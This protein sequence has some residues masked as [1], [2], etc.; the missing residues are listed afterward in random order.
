[1]RLGRFMKDLRE[2]EVNDTVR[3]H[4]LLGDCYILD[5]DSHYDFRSKISH[6]YGIHPEE[7]HVVG[8]GQL[9]F[10]IADGKR[11]R[12]FSVKSDIDVAIV[13]PVLFDRIWTAVVRYDGQGS[14]WRETKKMFR[15]YLMNGWI[16]PDALP[17]AESFSLTREWWQFFQELSSQT[18]DGKF[19]VSAGLY[20]TKEFLELYQERS[21]RSC[22]AAL[23][24]TR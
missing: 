20:R 8:S 16:R 2:R 22:K 7:V 17:Q 23:E 6:H 1:M 14:D 18:Q 4:I 3:K 21:V 13:S 15:K 11:Y 5:R 24:L 12:P 10:S 9:G 19:K